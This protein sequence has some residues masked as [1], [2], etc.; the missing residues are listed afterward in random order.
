MFLQNGPKMLLQN[1]PKTF[2]QNGP[3][4]LRANDILYKAYLPLTQGAALPATI[5][6]FGM[7]AATVPINMW[8]YAIMVHGNCSNDLNTI[9]S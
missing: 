9:M 7:P 3:K 5:I 2:L 1:G 8:L 4:M 6:S